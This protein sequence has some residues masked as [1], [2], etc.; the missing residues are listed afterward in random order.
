MTQIEVRKSEVWYKLPGRDWFCE[1]E[2]RTEAAAARRAEELR[3]IVS[4]TGDIVGLKRKNG[5]Y[6][7][8]HTAM[9]RRGFSDRNAH[10]KGF[11][12]AFEVFRRPANDADALCFLSGSRARWATYDS[13]KALID[14]ERTFAPEYVEEISKKLQP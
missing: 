5:T 3:K 2:H 12:T 4:Y 11:L 13:K 8:F 9:F 1:S 10:A 14:D 6:I 7:V